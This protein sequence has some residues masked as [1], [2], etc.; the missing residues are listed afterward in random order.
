[1]AASE[2]TG[3]ILAGG[4]GRRMGGADKGLLDYRGRP[5]VE[6]VIERLAPQVADVIISANRHPERYRS[7]G[8]AVVADDSND[9]PGPLAGLLAGLA[10]CPTDWLVCVPCD[11]PQLPDDLV[12]RLWQAADSARARMAVAT[13][14]ESLQPT[15]QLCHRS[16]LPALRATL[17]AGR[18]KLRD[19]CAEQGAVPVTFPDTNAFRN[20]NNPAE[21]AAPESWEK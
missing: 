17:A 3:L 1:L 5:L 10:A 9:F 8:Y 7:Y 18:R 11:C 16:L 12:A 13:T 2:V 19:W 20:L 6:H 14:H 21:L 4:A 15:F